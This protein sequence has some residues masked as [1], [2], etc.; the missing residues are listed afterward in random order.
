MAMHWLWRT[1][2]ESQNVLS[3]LR[4]DWETHGWWNWNVKYVCRCLTNANTPI[5]PIL[6]VPFFTSPPRKELTIMELS[7]GSIFW[8]VHGEVLKSDFSTLFNAARIFLSVQWQYFHTIHPHEK[9]RSH[10][11][12]V[13]IRELSSQNIFQVISEALK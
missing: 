11:L 8:E 1:M 5:L 12:W 3:L 2:S 10:I 13:V 4:P 9:S 7:H 6:L